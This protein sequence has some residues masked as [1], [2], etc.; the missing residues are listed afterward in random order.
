MPTIAQ[1]QAADLSMYAPVTNPLPVIPTMINNK[2]GSNSSIRC[3]LPPFNIDPDTL[4]QFEVGSQTPQIRV[5][6]VPVQTGNTTTVIKS[7]SGFIG[8]VGTSAA[9]ASGSSSG[10]SGSGSSSSTNLTLKSVVLTTGSISVSGSFIG[11]VLMAKSFQLISLTTSQPCDVRI[12]GAANIQ[13][14]DATRAI[15]SPVPAEVSDNI[16]VDVI[17]DTLP[18]TWGCQSLVGSNQDVPQSTN[19]YVSVL[20]TGNTTLS[21]VQVTISYLPLET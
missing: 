2:L 10:G 6:P 20:N 13:S 14:F 1:S 9:T 4:R 12:Y 18:F 5:L 8:S 7:A 17:F 19:V 21:P 16:I 11:T 15:D 3:P